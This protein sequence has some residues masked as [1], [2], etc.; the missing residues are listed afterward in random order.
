M[1]CNYVLHRNMYWAG[2]VWDTQLLPEKDNRMIR[3]N[4]TE[5]NANNGNCLCRMFIEVRTHEPWLS[6]ICA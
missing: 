1:Q 2:I 5:T 3:M 4:L 6:G